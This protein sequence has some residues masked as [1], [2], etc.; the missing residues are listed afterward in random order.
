MIKYP[1]Y[2][3]VEIVCQIS[4][5]V[6]RWSFHGTFSF[7]LCS[8]KQFAHR[9]AGGPALPPPV[10]PELSLNLREAKCESAKRVSGS[11]AACI[12][13]ERMQPGTCPRGTVKQVSPVF[14]QM[15]GLFLV[16][17]SKSWTLKTG[18]QIY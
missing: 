5:S 8:M 4:S 1:L 10:G 13:E 14:F 18:I 16:S 11:L 15:F 2:M 12:A 6:S 17:E 3:V 7:R 9:A